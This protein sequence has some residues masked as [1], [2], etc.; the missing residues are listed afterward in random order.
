MSENSV[1]DSTSYSHQLNKVGNYYKALNDKVLI[2]TQ[3][4]I[5]TSLFIKITIKLI[6]ANSLWVNIC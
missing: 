1:N 3:G 6:K 2:G 4:G 5:L